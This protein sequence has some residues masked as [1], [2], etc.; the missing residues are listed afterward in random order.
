MNKDLLDRYEAAIAKAKLELS[1][2][3]HLEE[4][5]NNAG[6]RKMNANKAE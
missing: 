1:V 6:I 3:S 4:C 5:G 2:A